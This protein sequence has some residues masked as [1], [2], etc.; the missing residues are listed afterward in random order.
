[1]P[2]RRMNSLKSRAINCE[3]VLLVRG[4]DRVPPPVFQPVIARSPYV[5]LVDFAV[6]LLPIEKLAARH[7]GPAHQAADRNL[8][9]AGPAVHKVRHLVAQVMRHPFLFQLSPR[10]FFNATC[11]S[12]SSARTSFLRASFS[13]RA[14]TLRSRAVEGFSLWFSKISL[15][16]SKNSCCQR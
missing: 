12:I 6:A 13:S 2:L 4:D 14:L 11:S 10:L 3:R 9:L 7:A 1:M 16:R 15:P 8:G 5:V